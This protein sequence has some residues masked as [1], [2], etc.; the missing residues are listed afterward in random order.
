MASAVQYG[1]RQPQTS[2]SCGTTASATPP[3]ASERPPKTP[4]A[5]GE[6]PD[7]RTSALPDTN[8]RPVPTPTIARAAMPS[9]ASG[10]ARASAL[11]AERTTIAAAPARA[12]PN[13]SLAL[14]P[15]I[16]TARCVTTIAVVRS[17]IA[18]SPTP[19][20]RDSSEAIPPRLPKFHPLVI[21]SA[22]PATTPRRATI[23]VTR[24]RKRIRHGAH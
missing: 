20:D 22:Q 4:C 11:P 16:W 2:S 23:Q 6:P 15:G 21:P 3:G 13:L 7:S 8:A 18:A 14:P 24:I 17:P 19:Y 12:G 1:A 10:P 5:S 9:A